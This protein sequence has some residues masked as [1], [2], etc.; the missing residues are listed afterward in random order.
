[1]IVHEYRDLTGSGGGKMATREGARLALDPWVVK[2]DREWLEGS[3]ALLMPPPARDS[4]GL[5]LA[6]EGLSCHR[7]HRCQSSS[8]LTLKTLF[9]TRG[10]VCTAK[11]VE[12]Y[13][14]LDKDQE[15]EREVDR[16]RP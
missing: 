13:S 5:S 3:M 1:M 8:H 9:V 6:V 11:Q 16:V 15:E 2:V 14:D 12:S 10:L 4:L 7:H